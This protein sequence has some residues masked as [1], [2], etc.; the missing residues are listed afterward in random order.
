MLRLAL[1]CRNAGRYS[2][3]R[4]GDIPEHWPRRGYCR[5]VVSSG[6][7]HDERLCHGLIECSRSLVGAV[8]A[9]DISVA[10]HRPDKRE[11]TA[12]DVLRLRAQFHPYRRLPKNTAVAGLNPIPSRMR[13]SRK[14]DRLQGIEPP[15]PSGNH[16]MPDPRFVVPGDAKES[17][18][19]GHPEPPGEV[20][21][22][23]P[24]QKLGA[25][26]GVP[27]STGGCP[28]LLLQLP[29]VHGHL[30]HG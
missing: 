23:I 8:K 6:R 14:G 7:N 26:H 1:R 3:S 20:G 19:P 30:I 25:R 27:D 9:E 5:L 18:T 12:E 13:A 17:R 29:P 10:S 2:E 24:R 28:T 11:V 4:S 22:R 16:Q 15:R 21:G